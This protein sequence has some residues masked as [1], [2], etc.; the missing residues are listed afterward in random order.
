ALVD[1]RGPNVEGCGG[2]FEAEADEDQS[3]CGES[4]GRCCGRFE[5]VGNSVDIGRAGGA[6]GER[7]A[8]EKEG[9]GK[10]AEQEVLDGG[11]GAGGLTL[12]E[13]AEDVGRDRG[14]L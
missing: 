8:V 6:E 9:G 13:A 7:D 3:Q 2:D 4:Q 10:G 1:I 12:A 14:D 11:S 5:T